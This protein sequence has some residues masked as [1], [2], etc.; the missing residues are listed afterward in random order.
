MSHTHVKFDVLLNYC[1]HVYTSEIKI[2]D[3]CL[4]VLLDGVLM[5]QALSYQGFIEYLSPELG[6]FSFKQ[7]L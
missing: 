3:Q 5:N 1:D 7:K 4:F 2:Q 6:F